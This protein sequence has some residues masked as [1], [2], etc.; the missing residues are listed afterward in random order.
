LE[1]AVALQKEAGSSGLATSCGLT[2]A[3]VAMEEFKF[4]EADALAHRAVE[5]YRAG[6][7]VGGVGYANLVL[8]RSLLEEGKTSEAASAITEAKSM[9]GRIENQR[10]RLYAQMVSA[11]VD[12]ASGDPARAQAAIDS[13]GPVIDEAAADGSIRPVL[14]GKYAL[15]RVEL[16]AG[17][18]EGRPRLEAVRKEAA[19]RGFG[20]IAAKCRFLLRRGAPAPSG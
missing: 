14:W 7:A 5:Q 2:L 4:P 13:L 3:T 20:L 16:E 11:L 17:K 6:H 9:L 19:A 8:A 10:V 15:G 12:G 18:P 1:E